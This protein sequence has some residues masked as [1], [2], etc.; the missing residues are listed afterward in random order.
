MPVKK[1][2]D[3]TQARVPDNVDALLTKPATKL[4][5]LQ[6]ATTTLKVMISQCDKVR[7]AEGFKAELVKVSTKL[8][9]TA[10]I[11]SKICIGEAPIRER[12]P[13]LLNSVKAQLQEVSALTSTGRAQFGI[14]LDELG[15]NKRRRNTAK[16]AVAIYLIA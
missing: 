6:Q 13:K 11:V 15:G 9:K 14:Q 8:D 12:V 3:D 16:Q 5:E 1:E 7:F 10:R 2:V 4:N